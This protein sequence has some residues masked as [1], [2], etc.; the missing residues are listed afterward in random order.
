MNLKKTLTKNYDI[1]LIILGI[2]IG[3]I[4]AWFIAPVEWTDF[5]YSQ[6]VDDKRIAVVYALADLAA[7]DAD[8][9]RLR[10]VLHQWP[11]IDDDICWLAKYE[12]D[13]AQKIRLIS[14]AHQVNGAGCND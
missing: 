4:Y 7:Y 9:R 1:I 8:S 12:P 11:D 5:E 13:T 10:A 2:A 14:L 3:I 6:L